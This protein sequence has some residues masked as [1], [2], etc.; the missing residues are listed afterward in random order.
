MIGIDKIE[1]LQRTKAQNVSLF[2]IYFE[3]PKSCDVTV[4]NSG[5]LLKHYIKNTDLESILKRR[6]TVA[7]NCKL[8]CLSDYSLSIG[9]VQ[10]NL[11]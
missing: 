9:T 1:Q 6:N 11:D 5:V 7:A 8:S 10:L 4:G 3:K 2:Y